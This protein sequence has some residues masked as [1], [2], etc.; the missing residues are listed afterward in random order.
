MI[1]ILS[2][3]VLW[4]AMLFPAHAAEP[5]APQTAQDVRKELID[6]LVAK[7]AMSAA[8]AAELSAEY[9]ESDA[10]LA[11]A[12]SWTK[13]L[14]WS[15]FFKVLGVILL[16]VAFGGTIVRI[17]KGLWELIEQV[18]MY[19][20]QGVFGAASVFGTVFPS[21]IWASQ[22][23]YVVLFCAFANLIIFG[24]VVTSYKQ[25]QEWLAKLFNLGIPEFVVA[26]AW[27]AVYFGVLAVAHDS[28]IFGFFTT[29]AIS[30]LFGFGLYYSP[31]VLFLNQHE[32]AIPALV[33]SHSL[34]LI[35]YGFVKLNGISVPYMQLFTAGVEY[36]WSL[37][38]GISFLITLSPWASS[39][40]RVGSL[41]PA[42]LAFVL[43]MVA[44]S[45]GLQSIS[46][47]LFICFVLV[48]LEWL[49]Y[50]SWSGGLI[51]GSL[52]SGLVLF[53]GGIMLE[54]HGRAILTAI[55][56]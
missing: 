4:A 36:Y 12:E 40:D 35:G 39:K 19:V 5:A 38:L 51:I 2:A 30:A 6:K 18:P 20:Y 55:G 56:F 54:K 9:K 50:A 17:I 44:F 42:T 49:M 53:T 22:S 24:W 37:A 48:A 1:R 25:V 29:V 14:S 23:F 10:K 31:G 43:S 33:W 16:L 34:L 26:S 11:Q 52:C 45:Y 21:M 15:G 28:Q 27:M 32:K 41:I 3:I 8:S 13:W 47:V 46:T 7:G